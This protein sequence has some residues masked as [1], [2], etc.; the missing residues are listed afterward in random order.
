MNF[1]TENSTWL[2]WGFII[3]VILGAVAFFSRNSLAKTDRD[4]QPQERPNE[5]GVES[6]AKTRKQ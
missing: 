5:T 6:I 3:F 2:L 4:P 1:L